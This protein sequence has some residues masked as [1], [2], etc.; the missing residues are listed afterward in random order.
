MRAARPPLRITYVTMKRPWTLPT[1]LVL[2]GLVAATGPF[3]EGVPGIGA[4]V[5][6]AFAVLAAL[7]SP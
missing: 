6:A 7:N 2:C 1:L 4:A 5:V 3:R